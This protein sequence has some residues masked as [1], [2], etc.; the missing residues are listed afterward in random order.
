MAVSANSTAAAPPAKEA[1]GR[2]L[3][4]QLVEHKR[5]ITPVLVLASLCVVTAISYGPYVSGGRFLA[6]DWAN[7][8]WTR[9]GGPGGIGTLDFFWQV[10][11]FR[12]V[13]VLYV[14][15]V[16][17]VLGTDPA[18][19]VVW[20]LVL[21]VAA[22]FALYVVLRQYRLPPLVA[23]LPAALVIPFPFAESI[24]LWTTA[25]SVSL[26]VALYLAGL[27]LALV[28][29][30]S[31]RRL[32][33]LHL[34]SLILYALSILMYEI[35]APAVALS[36]LAYLV[37]VRSRAAVIRGVVDLGLAAALVVFVTTGGSRRSQDGS[38]DPTYLWDRFKLFGRQALSLLGAS[39]LADL[40][41]GKA[42]LG[43]VAIVI[44]IGLVVVAVA[45]RAR[46]AQPSRLLLQQSCA[47]SVAGL[48]VIVVGYLGF[49][50][51][52]SFYF[53]VAEGLTDRVNAGAAYGYAMVAAGLAFG[54]G[55]LVAAVAKRPK[56]GAAIGA[57]LGI[58]LLAGFIHGTR[59]TEDRYIKAGEIQDQVM[60][61]IRSTVRHP[62]R[63]S[64]ILAADY[65]VTTGQNIPSFAL[66]NDLQG[67]VR[68][69]YGRED[70]GALP[71]RSG[72][73]VTCGRDGVHVGD[74]SSPDFVTLGPYG[75][76][77]LVNVRTRR[78][79][80]VRTRAQ[81]DAVRGAFPPGPD[82][83]A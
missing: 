41:H 59:Q 4:A 63:G 77:I 82:L 79:V 50:P 49:V 47:L 61:V 12:P 11:S 83:A 57:L 43:L 29:L 21:A 14:P 7:A 54:I 67:A 38:F 53:P 32:A 24:R 35:T 56:W 15:A 66:S 55:A 20:S 30:T 45:L 44:L 42:V 31:A 70:L 37:R 9:F 26:V 8:G 52:A 13:L 48:V 23:V 75:R 6:D 68:L 5:I 27:A 65:P 64:L 62:P 1:T 40:V 81:C 74:A 34:G 33:V 39:S 25:S 19:H 60:S 76:T 17:T 58:V 73:P 18:A 51:A 36:G 71:L 69:A 28:A 80:T 3:R 16:H 22:A 2:R 46:F 72:V 78:R 10:T